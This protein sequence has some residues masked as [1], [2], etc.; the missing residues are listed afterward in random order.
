M[1]VHSEL[2]PIYILGDF[3]VEPQ[4]SGWK[5][6][7]PPALKTGSWKQQGLPFYSYTVSYAGTYRLAKKPGNVKVRLGKWSGTLAEVLV[8]GKSAGIIGWQPYEIDVSS[9]VRSGNNRV[10]VVVY[11]SLKNLLG[12][13]HGKINR[14]LTGPGSFRSAPATTPPGAGYDLEAY[15]LME[16]FQ[17]LQAAVR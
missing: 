5:L 7:A 8:N 12:P 16:D 17:V 6:T 4:A 3:G 10:E 13:H 11:G 9:L 15:G 14:G 2:E 1:S